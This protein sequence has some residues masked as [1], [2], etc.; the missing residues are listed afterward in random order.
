MKM[1]SQLTR[2]AM[3]R[4]RMLHTLSPAPYIPPSAAYPP[5]ES[6]VRPL[7]PPQTALPPV[8]AQSSVPP[9]PSVPARP[10]SAPPEQPRVRSIYQQLMSSHDRMTKRHLSHP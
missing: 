9:Q 6:S 4:H 1:V 5:P 8:P 10:L 7:Y 3:N 2:Q